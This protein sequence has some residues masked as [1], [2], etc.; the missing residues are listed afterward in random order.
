MAKD[1]LTKLG[2]TVYFKSEK[3]NGEFLALTYGALVA[4]IVKDNISVDGVNQKLFKIG[5]NIG[6][7]LIDEYLSKAGSFS[8]KSFKESVE[9]IA[10]VGFKMFL[11]INANS[12][13]V[14]EE[15]NL[16]HITFEDNPLEMFIEM[17]DSLGDLEYSNVICGTI[18]G[19]LEQIRMRV[20]CK[21]VRYPIKKDQ[22][23]TISIQ[24]QEI[25]R[26]DAS[27]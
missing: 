26:D 12:E 23:Y 7:R 9:A 10:K 16:Y 20:D 19:A 5:Q 22:K 14:D 27:D 3:A 13:V 25:I 1:R 15:K 21:F 4:Q 24:L 18:A 11:G 6:S 2:E 8:C 17:S